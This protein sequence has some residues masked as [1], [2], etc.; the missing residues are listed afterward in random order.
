MGS[1]LGKSRYSYL[2]GKQN[3]VA[4]FISRTNIQSVKKLDLLRFHALELS[5]VSYD[6][7]ELVRQVIDGVNNNKKPKRLENSQLIRKT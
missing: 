1:V 3:V 7:H 4:D 5:A 6:D 2:P